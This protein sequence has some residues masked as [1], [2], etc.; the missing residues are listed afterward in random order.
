MAKT[1]VFPAPPAVARCLFWEA[2]GGGGG[3]GGSIFHYSRRSAKATICLSQNP[4]LQK[5]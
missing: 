1:T 5:N 3:G 4:A 2:G